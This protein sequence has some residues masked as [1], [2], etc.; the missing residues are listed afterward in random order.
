M[1]LLSLAYEVFHNLNV[2]AVISRSVTKHLHNLSTSNVDYKFY[3]PQH[4]LR[5]FLNSQILKY[6]YLWNNLPVI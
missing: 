4:R 5:I 1:L 6:I 2:L 3:A